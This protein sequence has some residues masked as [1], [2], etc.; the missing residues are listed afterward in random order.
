MSDWNP[1]VVAVKEVRKHLNADA[2]SIVITTIGDYPIVTK[3]DQYKPGDKVAYIPIDSIVPDTEQ[4][5]FL[6]PKHEGSQ[7]TKFEVGFVPER[8]RRIKAKKLRG[9]YSQ[10][11]LMALP[12]E[13]EIPF[14]WRVWYTFLGVIATVYRLIP[15]LPKWSKHW[16]EYKIGDSVVELFSLTKW[17]EEE[18]DNIPGSPKDKRARGETEKKPEGWTIPY[19][20]IE[21]LRKYI[22]CIHQ[23]DVIVLTEK[24]HGANASFCH[25]GEK[26][27]VKSRNFFKRGE[28]EIPIFEDT[29]AVYVDGQE[30]QLPKEG[31]AGHF[32]QKTQT[33]TRTIPST[34]QWWDVARRY[35]LTTKLSQYPGLVFFG[36]VYGQVKGF[37]YDAKVEDGMLLPRVRFFDTWDLKQMKYLDY[38]DFLS[39][40]KSAGLDVVPELY[41]GQWLGK[42][43]M[44]SYAEGKTTLGGAHVREGFVL[45]TVKERYDD[46]LGRVQMKLVGEGYN[47][48]K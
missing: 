15:G 5:H 11:M 26:L 22:D 20:D 6:C 2:L 9:Q 24:I 16:S 21:G 47:L 32:R 30:W 17:E 29:E 43:K 36:E 19:Y 46:R 13:K 4:F 27:W 38:D 7:I 25:D 10:G 34:D 48:Q 35:D 37:R 45:R 14:Y 41:R 33:G 8:Y 28:I 42:D 44:Y 12:G 39:I 3:L 1:Q 23:S 40:C 31:F 18:E